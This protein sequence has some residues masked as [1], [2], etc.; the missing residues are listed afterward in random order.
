MWSCLLHGHVQ[1]SQLLP[2][3]HLLVV[4]H[5]KAIH[6]VA[7]L[8]GGT[9]LM[10]VHW[11]SLWVITAGML[12]TTPWLVWRAR[13]AKVQQCSKAQRVAWTRS[14][15]AC[16]LDHWMTALTES[17]MIAGMGTCWEGRKIACMALTTIG[18][19]IS[20][21]G[22]IEAVMSLADNCCVVVGSRRVSCCTATYVQVWN[23]RGRRTIY[24][25]SH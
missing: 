12:A 22:S 8:A 19:G 23:K 2:S 24:S 20:D 10:L 15:R 25:K 14:L 17:M 5:N 11:N 13:Q 21:E 4:G 1:A 3:K 6:A 9:D 7:P 16:P 18:R